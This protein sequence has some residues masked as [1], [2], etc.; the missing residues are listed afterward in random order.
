MNDLLA[1]LRHLPDDAPLVVQTTAGAL[2]EA[3]EE[4]DENPDRL[5]TTRNGGGS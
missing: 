4:R 1:A 3:L 2:R 5:V